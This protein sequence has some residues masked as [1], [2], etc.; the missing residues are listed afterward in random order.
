MLPHRFVAPLLL[1]VAVL[2][3][4]A[5]LYG[6]LES[7]DRGILPIDSSGTLEIGGIHEERRV[8]AQYFPKRGRVLLQYLIEP[9]PGFFRVTVVRGREVCTQ[10]P[11]RCGRA[12]LLGP[13]IRRAGILGSC[14]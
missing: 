11:A 14:G 7:G 8:Q 12:R 5:V 2:G 4:S 3:V 6:Q 9:P 1:L 13:S 10:R